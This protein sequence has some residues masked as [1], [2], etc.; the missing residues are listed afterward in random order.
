[1]LVRDMEVPSFHH[2]ICLATPFGISMENVLV[3]P[4]LCEQS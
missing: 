4:A 1:M 2:T 3:T